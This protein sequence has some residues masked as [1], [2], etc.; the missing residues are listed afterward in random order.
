MNELTLERINFT[1][2]FFPLN[3]GESTSN[4]KKGVLRVVMNHLTAICLLKVDTESIYS[5]LCKHFSEN[6]LSWDNL[7]SIMMDSCNV[8]RQSKAGL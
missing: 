7:I 8:I 2:N 1:S 6:D 3:L 5:S 4:N